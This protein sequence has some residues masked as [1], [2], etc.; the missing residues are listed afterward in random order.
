MLRA[1]LTDVIEDRLRE[2]LIKSGRHRYRHKEWLYAY[3]DI[4]QF[5]WNRAEYAS[6]AFE[7]GIFY[8]TMPLRVYRRQVR[9]AVL[10]SY[11]YIMLRIIF[12]KQY[13]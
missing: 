13:I 9:G 10:S 12:S 3:I 4:Q 5:G 7:Q 1:D 6:L 8:F 2:T 11:S